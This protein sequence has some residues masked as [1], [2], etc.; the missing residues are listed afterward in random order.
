[1]EGKET[2]LYFGDNK[3]ANAAGDA[4]VYPASKFCGI[5]VASDVT[6]KIRFRGLTNNRNTDDILMTHAS[7]KHKELCE[8]LDIL[9]NSDKNDLVVVYDE[10]NGIIHPLLTELGVA[11]TEIEITLDT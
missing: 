8:A 4:C 2:Y 1:M 3:G 11:P 9:M 6:T 7:G 5:D 10:D